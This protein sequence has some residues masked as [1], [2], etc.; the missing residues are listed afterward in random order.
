MKQFTLE[1]I[2]SWYFRPFPIVQ[3]TAGINEDITAIFETG[4]LFALSIHWESVYQN[5]PFSWLLVPFS[6][7]HFMLC[8]DVSLEVVFWSKI[9][10]VI[11]NLWCTG[12]LLGPIVLWLEGIGVDMGGDITSTPLNSYQYYDSEMNDLVWCLDWPWIPIL[13]P[14]A[15]NPRILF[16]Y[17]NEWKF[18]TYIFWTYPQLTYHQREISKRSLELIRKAKPGCTC[19]NANN[20]ES[21]FIVNGIVQGRNDHFDHRDSEKFFLHE[22]FWADLCSLSSSNHKFKE[23]TM[24]RSMQ[25]K[26]KD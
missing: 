14:G 2:K 12:E 10:K 17:L 7:S 24:D 21:S 6:M 25:M 1:I 13:K 23:Q 22:K 8:L 18:S 3:I 11:A 9:F 20:L 19:S 26:E 5:I 15:W 16:V 4:L